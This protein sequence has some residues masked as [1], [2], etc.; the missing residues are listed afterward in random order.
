[1]HELS[2]IAYFLLSVIS[3]SFRIA[4]VVGDAELTEISERGSEEG[5]AHAERPEDEA[6]GDGHMPVLQ[7]HGPELHPALRWR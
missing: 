4:N 2:T 5:D 1:M 7:E 3:S 6:V